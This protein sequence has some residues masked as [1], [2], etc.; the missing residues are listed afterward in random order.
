[1]TYEQLSMLAGQGSIRSRR[2]EEPLLLD[3][4]TV[5]EMVTAAIPRGLVER[6]ARRLATADF[7]HLEG[8]AREVLLGLLREYKRRLKE[9]AHDDGVSL[10][11]GGDHVAVVLDE[12]S[13]IADITVTLPSDIAARAEARIAADLKE[14]FDQGGVILHELL[15]E[16]LLVAAGLERLD[17]DIIIS[18]ENECELRRRMKDGIFEVVTSEVTPEDLKKCVEAIAQMYLEAA[19]V[20]EVS[21][22]ELEA[23]AG[24]RDEEEVR[25]ARLPEPRDDHWQTASAILHTQVRDAVAQKRF[26]QHEDTIYPYADI[27]RRSRDGSGLRGSAQLLPPGHEK[28]RITPDQAQ[29]WA[30]LLHQ[31]AS[32]LS[33][34]D[35]DMLDALWAAWLHQ[36]GGDPK[37]SA[38]I[39][40]DDLLRMRGLVPKP[41][42]E[43][44]GGY[45]PKQRK[46]VVDSLHRLEALWIDVGEMDV[47]E[48]PHGGKPKKNRLSV[49]SRAIAITDRAGLK[50]ERDLDVD[51]I[52]YKP[53]EVFAKV[54]S[55]SGRQVAWLSMAALS[56]DYAK[57]ITPKRLAKYLA[58]QFRVNA[59]YGRFKSIKVS[60]LLQAVG[61]NLHTSRPLRV[62]ERLEKAL[63][64]LHM[65]GVIAGW[66][67]ADFVDRLQES[68]KGW[69]DKWLESNVEIEP[70]E[71]IKDFYVSLARGGRGKMDILPPPDPA[72]LLA[73]MTKKDPI[74]DEV[75]A[76]RKALGL[77]QARLSEI[78]GVNKSVISMVENGRT[79]NLP[80]ACKALR[81]WLDE[82]ADDPK[83]ST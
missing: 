59:R 25:P 19:V 8:V 41:S 31:Q 24:L 51:Y 65:D 37:Y 5:E 20:E 57:E 52:K 83:A 74:C 80:T 76:R 32:A 28:G 18:R 49:Q 77:T 45:T 78:T 34:L 63:D 14:R 29:A 6:Y 55:G 33:D 69:L 48:S 47:F 9:R 36:S 58:V 61:E 11:H 1:M 35:A 4:D 16:W 60:T 40:I 43:W 50:V 56:Y 70:P 79:Q 7:K 3:A 66:Q 81:K 26:G 39:K 72:T 22:P 12:D 46:A 73:A 54:L 10:I 2:P 68:R 53:G 23:L 21:V 42:G 38:V 15:S 67:Y 44:R 13:G 17:E 82:T 71:A 27:S 75:R 30:G 64:R 62:R